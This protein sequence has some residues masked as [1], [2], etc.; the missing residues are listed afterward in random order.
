[1]GEILSGPFFD[2]T[3]KSD[4]LVL[5]LG[6]NDYARVWE[7]VATAERLLLLHDQEQDDAAYLAT[8]DWIDERFPEV[9]F[10]F[11]QHR[12]GGAVRAGLFTLER[13]SMV[14]MARGRPEQAVAAWQQQ[15]VAKRNSMW[16]RLLIE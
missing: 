3:S 16:N 8:L 6:F 11:A 1:M 14:A 13:R 15:T 10:P 12:F 9:D 2:L 4:A 5:Q 7:G